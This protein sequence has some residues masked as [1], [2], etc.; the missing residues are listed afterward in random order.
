MPGYMF[1]S[2]AAGEDPVSLSQGEDM[3][4]SW[5]GATRSPRLNRTRKFTAFPE[6]EVQGM[7]VGGQGGEYK[8]EF[9]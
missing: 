3:L 8:W 9:W 6:Q 2:P 4:E 7:G 1:P 5:L